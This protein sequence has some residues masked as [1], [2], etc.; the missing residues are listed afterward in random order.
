MSDDKK[1]GF[2][3][4]GEPMLSTPRPPNPETLGALGQMLGGL[5]A[6][7]GKSLGE[8]LTERTTVAAA[9][10]SGLLADPDWNWHSYDGAETNGPQ[11]AAQM[12]RLYADTLLFELDNIEDP[13]FAK[14]A[15]DAQAAET[16]YHD[17]VQRLVEAV[18]GFADEDFTCR[19]ER[20][21]ALR[22]RARAVSEA[23][24]KL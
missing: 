12:A 9:A 16:A 4:F 20:V 22:A 13:R 6:G 10:L 19:A 24:K 15:E 2:K 14:Q 11:K 5:G 7:L 17:A 3:F 1:P 23:G 18:D 21:D 8:K